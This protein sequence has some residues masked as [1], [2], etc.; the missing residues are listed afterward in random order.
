VL[1]QNVCA[2]LMEEVMDV[3]GDD[4]VIPPRHIAK[5]RAH[6]KGGKAAFQK[7]DK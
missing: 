5:N 6:K 2:E 4:F 7:V 1:L 3:G